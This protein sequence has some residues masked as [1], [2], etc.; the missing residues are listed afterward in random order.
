MEYSGT[1]FIVANRKLLD[2]HHGKDRNTRA[3]IKLKEKSAQEKSADHNYR[4]HEVIVQDTKK[5]NCPASVKIKEVIVFPEHKL[6]EN[7]KRKKDEASKLI[8]TQ[9]K[10]KNVNLKFERKFLVVL[11]NVK[12][13][14]FHFV[15]EGA[16]ISQSI[17]AVLSQKISSFVS[18]GVL[19]VKEM[20]R[21]LKIVVK[22]EIFRGKRLPPRSNR[23]FWPE[24][25]TIQN[26][27]DASKCKLRRSMIDQEN[28][29][30]KIKDWKIDQN[31]QKTKKS[32]KQIIQQTKLNHFCSYIKRS[33]KN[34]FFRGMVMKLH[35]LTLRIEQRGMP[36]LCSF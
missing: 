36:Y 28:L 15:E 33:G 30:D 23:R 35:L 21:H 19:T 25:K 22:N 26:H 29:L 8:R 4:K 9:I 2:C 27:I 11:P 18:E 17:D 6:N 16:G 7:K 12:D 24:T 34:A 20:K 5:F 13:H 31:V 1:P 3:K 10:G 32:K 14:K